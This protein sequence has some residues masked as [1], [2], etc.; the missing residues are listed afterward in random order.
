MIHES[1]GDGHAEPARTVAA[2]RRH[3][4]GRSSSRMWGGA[5]AE[6]PIRVSSMTTGRPRLG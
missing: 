3:V 2:G 6:T 5:P 1:F 4:D